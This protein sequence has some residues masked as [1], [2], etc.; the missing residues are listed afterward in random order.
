MLVWVHL[1]GWVNV[2][3]S[4]EATQETF[5]NNAPDDF[6]SAL[7][8]VT[9]WCFHTLSITSSDCEEIQIHFL[10]MPLWRSD[11]CRGDDLYQVC[12]PRLRLITG[13]I[14]R[15]QAK[16]FKTASIKERISLVSFTQRRVLH[17]WMRLLIMQNLREKKVTR[18]RLRDGNILWIT[19]DV[20]NT[21]IM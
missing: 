11:S 15:L 9:S 2:D 13:A 20:V 21:E 7:R 4:E 16:K 3:L 14:Q 17:D 1:S 18:F 6:T 12:C 8:A 19:C 10:W 5:S